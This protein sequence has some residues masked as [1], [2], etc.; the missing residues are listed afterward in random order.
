[1]QGVANVKETGHPLSVKKRWKT[2]RNKVTNF[3]TYFGELTAHE[4]KL[5]TEKF[6]LVNEISPNGPWTVP[7]QVSY[8]IYHKITLALPF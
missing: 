1:M 4:A 5:V 8:P 3:S 2:I 7:Y 6:K